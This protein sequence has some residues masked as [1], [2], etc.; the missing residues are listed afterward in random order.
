MEKV[1]HAVRGERNNYMPVKSILAEGCDPLEI[2]N[3][4]TKVTGSDQVYIADLAAILN[5]GSNRGLFP[6]LKSQGISL[7]VDAGVSDAGSALTIKRAGADRIIIGT[8]T[9]SDIDQLSEIIWQIDPDELVLSIDVKKGMVL[10]K[11]DGLKGVE[12]CRGI[13][14]FIRKRA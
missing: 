3:A 5:R 9:I 11:A 4:L 1:V 7:K 14:R 6:H 2:A 8:E 12:P 13:K 10:S